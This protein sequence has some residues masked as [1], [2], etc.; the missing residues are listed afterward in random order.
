MKVREVFDPFQHFCFF[1]D[2]RHKLWELEL[3]STRDPSLHK[4]RW[5]SSRCRWCLRNRFCLEVE[6]RLKSKESKKYLP[7]VNQASVVKSQKVW[8]FHL[9]F[10][11]LTFQELNKLSHRFV[12]F[13][14]IFHILWEKWITLRN[15]PIHSDNVSFIVDTFAMENYFNYFD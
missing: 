8:F 5:E 9:E 4:L 7:A 11:C 15:T 14:N 3:S 10:D 1:L 2:F 13:R 12:P 6:T